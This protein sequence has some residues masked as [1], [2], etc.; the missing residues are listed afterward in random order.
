MCSTRSPVLATA[1]CGLHHNM[2]HPAMRKQKE[3]SAPV[4]AVYRGL[5]LKRYSILEASKS[6]LLIPMPISW[7]KSYINM[8]WTSS[9][10]TSSVGGRKR[11]HICLQH[12]YNCG[13]PSTFKKLDIYGSWSI[14]C[15]R[16]I[17]EYL[18]AWQR[19]SSS[20]L[21][22]LHFDSTPTCNRQT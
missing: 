7:N 21:Y 3:T 10:Y 15:C 6:V 9:Y 14:I 2:L 5:C 17:I 1:V 16:A 12:I 20:Y 18:L 13:K 22:D 4:R 19:P 8:S 11:V